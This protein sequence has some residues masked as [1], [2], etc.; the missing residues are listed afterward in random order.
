[1][2]E[3][4]RVAKVLEVAD[5]LLAELDDT[6]FDDCPPDFDSDG[7]DTVID[8]TPPH[9]T[10]MV[11]LPPAR[12]AAPDSVVVD[13]EVSLDTLTTEPPPAGVIPMQAM[14][15]AA[16]APRRSLWRSFIGA[17]K[18]LFGRAPHPDETA[19]EDSCAW[20]YTMADRMVARARNHRAAHGSY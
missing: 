18:R 13:L 10:A 14:I 2:D 20:T 16:P 15:V 17:I 8:A 1:M 4:L 7:F 19:D 5:E 12:L 6:M 9:M 11:E 3:Q